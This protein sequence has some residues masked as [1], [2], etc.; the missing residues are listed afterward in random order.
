MRRLKKG[1]LALLL[2]VS[3]LFS[4]TGLTPQLQ[5][6]S[7]IARAAVLMQYKFNAGSQEFYIPQKQPEAPSESKEKANTYFWDAEEKSITLENSPDQGYETYL[8]D[9]D[10]D[11]EADMIRINTS[12]EVK[13]SLM[14]EYA[15]ARQLRNKPKADN[16]NSD[17][18]WETGNVL[19]IKNRPIKDAL[20]YLI[21]FDGDA[22]P[23][24]IKT[25]LNSAIINK[26]KIFYK[27]AVEDIK[28]K[29]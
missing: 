29:Q 25:E 4:L 18:I 20:V 10:G 11:G 23:D 2:S 6:Q 17:Y 28:S 16:S 26:L 24:S 8:K 19:K 15:K 27:K 1:S 3:S 21:D 22:V 14:A 7:E 13:S 9:S 5:N 12:K